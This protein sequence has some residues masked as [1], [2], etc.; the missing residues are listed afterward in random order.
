M[1]E[2]QL[3]FEPLPGDALQRFLTDNVIAVNFARTGVA[4]WHPVGF[5]LRNARGEWLGGLT[6]HLWGGWLHVNFLWVTEVLRGQGHGT[7]LMDAAEAYAVERGCT[8]ATLE[9]FSF[10]APDFYAGRGYEV[11]GTLPDYPPGHSKFFLRKRLA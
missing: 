7:R 2:L 9:T 5:F 10:H 8:N 4:A 11:F 3:V 1:E 6:G